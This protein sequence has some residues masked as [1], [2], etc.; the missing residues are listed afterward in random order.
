M[1]FAPAQRTKP[2]LNAA[3]VIVNNDLHEKAWRRLDQKQLM[4]VKNKV[5]T[6]ALRQMPEVGSARTAASNRSENIQNVLDWDTED[7]AQTTNK[8]IRS[9][10]TYHGGKKSTA[11]RPLEKPIWRVVP[12]IEG[13]KNVTDA[14]SRAWIPA[15]AGL[16]DFSASTGPRSAN[17]K[18]INRNAV[19][20]K[21][22]PNYMY[23]DERAGPGAGQFAQMQRIQQDGSRPRENKEIVASN[24][25]V[26]AQQQANY[27]MNNA[28]GSAIVDQVNGIMNELVIPATATVAD[29]EKQFQQDPNGGRREFF[30]VPGTAARRQKSQSLRVLDDSEL[31]G[32]LKEMNLVPNPA[33]LA[34]DTAFIVDRSTLYRFAQRA[35]SAPPANRA[36]NYGSPAGRPS[37]SET[38]KMPFSPQPN[39]STVPRGRRAQS[40]PQEALK[41]EVS[42]PG[43][44]YVAARYESLKNPYGENLPNDK[45]VAAPQKFSTTQRRPANRIIDNLD[46]PQLKVV[47]EIPPMKPQRPVAEKRHLTP[48]Y[49]RRLRDVAGKAS[50]HQPFDWISRDAPFPQRARDYAEFDKAVYL[51]RPKPNFIFVDSKQQN[52]PSPPPPSAAAAT[53]EAVVERNSVALLLPAY[54][55]PVEQQ[56]DVATN[57]MSA[58][59][60]VGPVRP[61]S[62]VST[63]GGAGRVL[64]VTDATDAAA[65]STAGEKALQRRSSAMLLPAY[66]PPVDDA[67]A[68]VAKTPGAAAAPQQPVVVVK[69]RISR[70]STDLDNPSIMPPLPASNA[71]VKKRISRSSTHRAEDG[72]LGEFFDTDAVVASS[73]TTP[74]ISKATTAPGGATPKSGRSPSPANAQYSPTTATSRAGD[75]S[76]GPLS[77]RSGVSKTPRSPAW[78]ELPLRVISD[79]D[80]MADA[81]MC[82][83]RSKPLDYYKEQMKD[84]HIP[85]GFWVEPKESFEKADRFFI[86][87]KSDKEDVADKFAA[88]LRGPNFQF[89]GPQFES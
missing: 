89:V 1:S 30:V 38:E 49:A 35:Q 42:Q 72:A 75:Q 6:T 8:N 77:A 5:D 39:S 45:T 18:T 51:D 46:R 65:T 41:P 24:S 50:D 27:A 13:M 40:R 21:K 43:G 11:A 87:A 73:P 64:P 86:F 33:Q 29:D 32:L 57:T 28:P 16:D 3:Q 74:P 12:A 20:A 68:D 85:S 7:P 44:A 60:V 56:H 76:A 82:A 81:R 52:A 62:R 2:E 9:S 36:Y 22:L 47:G 69:P 84:H 58:P 48:D 55:P 23:P 61:V 66:A 54:A 34:D 14:S 71:G 80:G 83:D 19:G 17:A 53:T 59:P 15:G 31:Q 79:T 88:S 67:G 70:L 25:A 37:D 78:D 26:L 63:S 10:W 4:S